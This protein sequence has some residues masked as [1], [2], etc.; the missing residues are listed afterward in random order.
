MGLSCESAGQEN[1]YRCKKGRGIDLAEGFEKEFNTLL[2]FTLPLP[3]SPKRNQLSQIHKKI[4]EGQLVS[5]IM[6]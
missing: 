5:L 3:L 1:H 2:L 4:S 6:L